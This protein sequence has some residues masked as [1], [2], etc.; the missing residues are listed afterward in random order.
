MSVLC[1]YMC[2]VHVLV[3]VD[4]CMSIHVGTHVRACR[5]NPWSLGVKQQQNFP[6]PDPP[7]A[8]TNCSP[9]SVSFR[10]GHFPSSPQPKLS[11]TPSSFVNG[12]GLCF[13]LPPPLLYF[14][15]ESG[16]KFS[17]PSLARGPSSHDL[18]FLG[19]FPHVT[20][21]VPHLLSRM[22]GMI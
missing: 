12:L 2:G 20:W 17:V 7:A 15:G 10:C 9:A 5:L 1:V 11:V 4:V 19:T 22:N 8:T 13:P 18:S 16:L 6:F 14:P 21:D 3:H